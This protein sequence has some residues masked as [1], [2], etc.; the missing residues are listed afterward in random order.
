MADFKHTQNDLYGADE[1]YATHLLNRMKDSAQ[2]VAN[3]RGSHTTL[4]IESYNNDVAQQAYERPFVSVAGWSA[5]M[6][7]PWYVNPGLKG[8]EARLYCRVS[9]GELDAN[10]E[11]WVLAGSDRVQIRLRLLGDLK[12]GIDPWEYSSVAPFQDGVDPAEWGFGSCSYNIHERGL[13]EGTYSPLVMEIRSV[14]QFS[15]GAI[16]GNGK[17]DDGRVTW[18][19]IDTGAAITSYRAK[20]DQNGFYSEHSSTNAPVAGSNEITASVGCLTPS[21]TVDEDHEVVQW[22]DHVARQD[23]SSNRA[24]YVWPVSPQLADTSQINSLHKYHVPYIQIRAIE[25]WEEYE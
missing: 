24:M 15:K 11:G 19:K 22:F 4:T 2:W 20:A 25:I 3:N 17:I 23:S 18:A 10:P 7:M 13:V 1:S 5:V 8:F 6:R 21:L 9:N 14:S 12:A 16:I